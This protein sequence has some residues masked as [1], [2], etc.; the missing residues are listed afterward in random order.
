MPSALF[1][2]LTAMA[3]ELQSFLG[4]GKVTSA[5]LV[6][7]YLHEIEAHNDYLKAVIAIAPRASLLE[8][9]QVL[10]KERSNGKLRS[11]LHGI[12]ILVKDNIATHP[13][14]GMDTT[15]GS[16]AL[17]IKA[18]VLIIGKASLS[19]LSWYKIS[20]EALETFVVE[21]DDT[22]GGH[23]NPGG[24]PSG[25]A[26]AVSAGF[27]PFSIG[28]ETEGSL[29]MP[30]SRA[31]VSTIKPTIGIVSQ[32][33]LIPVSYLC[34]S[35][36]PM[37]KSVLDLANLMDVIVDPSTTRI[38]EGG[39]K[40]AMTNTWAEIRVGVL[41]PAKWNYPPVVFKPDEGATKQMNEAF[42]DAYCKLESMAKSFHKYVPLPNG[43]DLELDGADCL[44]TLWTG[45]FKRDFENYT[46]GLDES[47]VYTL[48]ELVDFNLKHADQELPPWCPKQ[49]KLEKAL[50]TNLTAENLD[51]ALAHA[52]KIG[53]TEGID[54]ILKEYNL[55]VIIGP[56]ESSMT[57]M[58]S[59]SGYPIASL[60]LGYLDFNGR[61]FGMAA[62][63]SGHQE[64]TLIK[65]QSAWE[66]TFPPR[67]RPPKDNFER[68]YLSTTLITA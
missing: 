39:Y 3:S 59:A 51:A 8:K 32:Q 10:D 22:F 52:R 66:A 30:G 17:L 45:Y 54:K 58:A 37:T 31:A 24:S 7:V 23:S 57:D 43:D 1:N 44:Q 63:A 61:P 11:Q 67:R 4:S 65:V 55:D 19:E 5:Q 35:A 46:S 29:I 27:A 62:L 53:R 48:Q 47:Q 49:D 33:G 64:A 60:P 20:S 42:Q 14:L 25:S 18:G 68:I 36:G 21:E 13:D 2:A 28:T 38:P 26:T 56:A 40:S 41:N 6:E 12:P 9:A 50:T 34:D 15:S 16:L